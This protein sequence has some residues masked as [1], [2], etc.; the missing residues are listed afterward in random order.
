MTDPRPEIALLGGSFNPPHV[1]H[2]M[3]AWWLLATQPVEEVWL[4]PTWR[5]PFGKELAPWEDRLRMCELAVEGLRGVR[6]CADEA[7]LAGDPLAGRT[8]RTLE[9]LSAKHPGRRF[10]LAIGTDLLRETDRWHRFDRVRELARIVVVA[11]QG[12]DAPA[13]TPALPDV[14]STAIR[15]AIARGEPVDGLVPRAVARYIAERR[16]YRAP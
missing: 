12:F 7:E 15:A 11:R 5:H 16:L 3:A 14:S 8:L 4:L 1:G 10:A 13:G 2:A 9:H 6:V